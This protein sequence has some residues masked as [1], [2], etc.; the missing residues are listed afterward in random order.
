MRSRRC[1]SVAGSGP[2]GASPGWGPGGRRFKSCLPDSDSQVQILRSGIRIGAPEPS[3]TAHTP[4]ERPHTT[5]QG[6][7]HGIRPGG[8]CR[9]NSI[10]TAAV[11]P[12]HSCGSE[13]RA[14]HALEDAWSSSRL[15]L[16]AQEG[17]SWRGRRLWAARSVAVVPDGVAAVGLMRQPH[18]CT[19]EGVETET[20]P[21]E[22]V[23]IFAKALV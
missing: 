17:W 16:K 13:T 11:L 5:A 3:S 12:F 20:F 21:A 1:W 22:E 19:E 7:A 8:R 6:T 23:E 4:G 2:R 18:G 10:A 14:D 15:S 9:R